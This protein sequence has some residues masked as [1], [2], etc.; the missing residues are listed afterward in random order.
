MMRGMDMEYSNGLMELFMKDS[1]LIIEQKAL[2]FSG[3]LRGMS[4]KEISRLIR[5]AAMEF[6]YMSMEAGMKVNGL[7]MCRKDRERKLGQME[8][9]TLDNTKMA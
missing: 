3:M 4:I 1:G 2:V 6:I 8:P 5:H 7:M 9:N